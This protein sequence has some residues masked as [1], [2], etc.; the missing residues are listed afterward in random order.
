MFV[1]LLNFIICNELS[2]GYL[3]V[4]VNSPTNWPVPKVN[5]FMAH[6]AESCISKAKVMGSIDLFFRLM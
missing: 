4:V 6:L 2:I 1:S 5:S 3:T